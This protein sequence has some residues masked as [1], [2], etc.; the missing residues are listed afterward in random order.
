MGALSDGVI[1]ADI[2]SIQVQSC[3]LF[4]RIYCVLYVLEVHESESS[5]SSSLMIVHDLKVLD[6]S[7]PL[8]DLA[9]VALLGSEVE[10]EDAE[11]TAFPRIVLFVS[12]VT[13]AVRHRRTSSVS[14]SLVTAPFRGPFPVMLV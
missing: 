8:K 4:F 14:V 11:A 5:R 12:L 6:L 10:A 3:S 9:Q 13:T 7:I 2:S 1:N